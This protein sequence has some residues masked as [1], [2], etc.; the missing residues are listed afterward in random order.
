MGITIAD[1]SYTKTKD[2]AV[3]CK[4]EIRIETKTELCGTPLVTSY[5]DEIL[6]LTRTL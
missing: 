2:F 3:V 6:P 4:I 1:V 5:Q